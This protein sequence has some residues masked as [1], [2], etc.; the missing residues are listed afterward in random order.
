M[1]QQRKQPIVKLLKPRV[2]G[3]VR[4]A[5]QMGQDAF[6]SPLELSLVK[7]MQS[8]R[9]ERYD[10]EDRP[11]SRLTS[12]SSLLWRTVSLWFQVS[13]VGHGFGN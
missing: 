6:L 13:G 9:Q 8:R 4:P 11:S 1:A 5:N 7:K 2:D 12:V 3:F 10:N